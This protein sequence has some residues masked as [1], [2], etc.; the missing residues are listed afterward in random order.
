MRACL[1]TLPRGIE[2]HLELA[3]QRMALHQFN[4]IKFYTDGCCYKV[5]IDWDY[6]SRVSHGLRDCSVIKSSSQN[7]PFVCTHKTRGSAKLDVV[8]RTGQSGPFRT[9]FKVIF[10][11]ICSRH[12]TMYIHIVAPIG[13]L[14]G[15]EG[16]PL[17]HRHDRKSWE[18]NGKGTSRC[19]WTGTKEWEQKL[20][21]KYG[22]DA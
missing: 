17:G 19:W 2:Y 18:E 5:L 14:G 4:N 20:K 3:E 13:C 21:E 1:H 6:I 16:L 15:H 11:Q 12:N 22:L 7:P 8:E 10:R 9:T